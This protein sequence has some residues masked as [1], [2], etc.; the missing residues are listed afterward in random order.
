MSF[1]SRNVS[2]PH[3]I[4]LTSQ[5]K[6][7]GRLDPN[8]PSQLEISSVR[9]FH[10]PTGVS[11]KQV[12]CFCFEPASTDHHFLINGIQQPLSIIKGLA[13]VPITGMMESFNRVEL[14]W[15]GAPL[16]KPQLPEHFAAWLEISDDSPLGS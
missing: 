8:N 6:V 9:T 13:S 5:W 15:R 3:R 10:R 11:N 12:I 16:E 7:D 2:R 4:S 14:R 1:A